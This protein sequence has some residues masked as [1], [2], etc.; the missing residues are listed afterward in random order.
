LHEAIDERGRERGA[1]SRID[2]PRGNEA[3]LLRFQELRFPMNALAFGFGGS[4]RPRD[5]RAHLTRRR[6][7]VLGV[8]LQQHLARDG[9]LGQRFRRLGL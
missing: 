4:Q 5:A 9:L 8:F 6:F 2:A 1:G 7:A 3:A